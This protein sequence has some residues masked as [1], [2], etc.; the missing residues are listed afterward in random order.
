MLYFISLETRITRIA[1]ED[2]DDFVDVGVEDEG[3]FCFSIIL[4]C[5]ATIGCWQ[6]IAQHG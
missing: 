5:F 2:I 1:V 6:G 4:F 3:I